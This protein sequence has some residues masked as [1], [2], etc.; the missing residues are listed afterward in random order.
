MVSIQKIAS[1]LIRLVIA[2]AVISLLVLIVVSI[3]IA[4]NASSVLV[5]PPTG[6]T[7]KWFRETL[8]PW[9]FNAVILSVEVA[10]VS[11][12]ASLSISLPA[13]FALARY[14]FH[15]KNSLNSLFLSPLV[16]PGV[17]TGAALL[18]YFRELN[19]RVV[20]ADLIVAHIL[21]TF[22][23]IVRTLAAT[24]EGLDKNTEEAA[25]N[26]GAGPFRTFFSITVPQ[27]YTAIIGA[28]IMSF[29]LSLDNVP[30]SIFLTSGT[31]ATL[32]VVLFYR[33]YN[34]FDPTIAAA[35]LLMLL[36]SLVFVIIFDRIL[37]IQN[38]FELKIGT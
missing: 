23:L 10:T 17:I 5:L 2:L 38:F 1:I 33:I 3:A 31:S 19:F 11:T 22:P 35:S 18:F 25:R 34:I 15:G 29:I 32:P 21:I 37:G 8:Q 27:I 14:Q 24:L 16:V 36:F 6:F 26:L 13:A 9:F 4:F 7:L 12:V 28:S 30:I 20:L